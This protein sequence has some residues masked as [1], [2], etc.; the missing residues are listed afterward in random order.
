MSEQASSVDLFEHADLQPEHL[1]AVIGQMSSALET[2]TRDSYAVLREAKAAVQRR[3]FAFDYG[4]DAV[5]YDLRRDDQA[6]T[7]TLNREAL[8]SEA[9]D[10]CPTEDFYDLMDTIDDMTVEQLTDI[11]EKFE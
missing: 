6:Q 1:R 4:L 2:G 5:P 8:V 11:V 10:L 7:R 3:G 9:L